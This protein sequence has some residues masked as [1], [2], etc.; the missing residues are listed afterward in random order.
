MYR[1]FGDVSERG[2]SYCDLVNGTY[3]DQGNCTVMGVKFDP[4]LIPE[5]GVPPIPGLPA[6][7]ATTGGGGSIP[8]VPLPTPPPQPTQPPPAEAKSS[9]PD[10]L[11]PAVIGVGAIAITAALIGSR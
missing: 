11:L 7:P 9:T 4:D 8:T 5:G 2:K 10:W 6:M 1:G 3:D